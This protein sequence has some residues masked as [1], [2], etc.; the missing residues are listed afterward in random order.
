MRSKMKSKKKHIPLIR[1]EQIATYVDYIYKFEPQLKYVIIESGLPFSFN[2]HSEKSEGYISRAI[3]T[4]LLRALSTKLS[5]DRLV[6]MFKYTSMING[7][8]VLQGKELSGTVLNALESLS[9]KLSL[10]STDSEFGI[11]QSGDGVYFFRIRNEWEDKYIELLTLNFMIC[12]VQNLSSR[13]WMPKKITLRSEAPLEVKGLIPFHDMKID[14]HPNTSAIFIEKSILE[15]KIPILNKKFYKEQHKYISTFH[16]SLKAL[17]TPYVCG[18]I[19][20][21]HE[22]ASYA[23]IGVRTLQRRLKEENK[24]FLGVLQDLLHELACD[25][26]INSE[27]SISEIAGQLGY[28]TVSHMCRA[29]KKISGVTPQQYRLLKKQNFNYKSETRT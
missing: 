20:T 17:L 15:R 10:D 13:T 5:E 18:H 12:T 23:N 25:A 8:I 7:Y 27:Q 2:P 22:A 14:Y 9:K 16:Y 4:K 1:T 26:L 28:S 29:F 21:I 19:P 6:K 11:K 24:T 3:A